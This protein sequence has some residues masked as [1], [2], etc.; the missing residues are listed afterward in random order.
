M[1]ASQGSQIP[2][3]GT[4]SLALL[5]VHGFSGTTLHLAW[6]EFQAVL[7]PAICSVSK[8]REGLRTLIPSSDDVDGEE[9]RSS[10]ISRDVDSF[11][12]LSTTAIPSLDGVSVGVMEEVVLLEAWPRTRLQNPSVMV[13][14]RRRGLD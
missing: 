3:E 10:T 12:V 8:R 1:S 5:S 6:G 11:W 9:D 2:L 7:S 14:I 13:G 4:E